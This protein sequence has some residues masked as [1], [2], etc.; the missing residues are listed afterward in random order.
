MKN[1]K[2]KN[3]IGVAVGEKVQW[4]SWPRHLG[5]DDHTNIWGA[6]P[7]EGSV[8]LILGKADQRNRSTGPLLGW[9][10]V[11]V[12][13]GTDR[14]PQRV[15]ILVLWLR[16]SPENW[17]KSPAP[18]RGDITWAAES[19][20]SWKQ[21]TTPPFRRWVH[22]GIPRITCSSRRK[23]CFCCFLHLISIYTEVNKKLNWIQVYNEEQLCLA[24]TP[25]LAPALS[26]DI[27]GYPPLWTLSHWAW[28]TL[29]MWTL[30]LLE[31]TTFFFYSFDSFF[32]Y[33]FLFLKNMLMLFFLDFLF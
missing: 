31:E 29:A 18:A 25:A 4:S 15:G 32:S 5:W 8:T 17:L 33:T 10:A 22:Q 27:E 3:K 21:A 12:L 13:P 7:W 9:P 11:L 6:A 23:L 26:G 19:S 1:R 20:C 24:P 2:I 14:F 30:V 16:K 28:W